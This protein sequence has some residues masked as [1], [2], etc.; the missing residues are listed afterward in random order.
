[1]KQKA[2]PTPDRLGGYLTAVVSV[3]TLAGT[4]DAAVI[5]FS[6][7]GSFIEGTV[8]DGD[9]PV[10][11]ISL[12]DGTELQIDPYFLST[13]LELS[14]TAISGRFTG[15]GTFFGG[16]Y[17]GISLLS[18]GDSIFANNS[19]TYPYIAKL[20]KGEIPQSDFVGDVSGYIGFVTPNNNKGWLS[21]DFNSATGL[22]AYNGGA[23]ATMGEDLTAGATAVSAI[24]EPSSAL[25]TIGLLAG[26]MMI[27]RRKQ[28]A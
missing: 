18:F 19:G 9:Q 8:D 4:A 22:F 20:V 25:A 17:P 12:G 6:N 21:V 24:P 2:K 7:S 15:V 27:R 11:V 10:I 28:A 13:G 26:G 5:T 14:F 23:V 16:F 3:G 1:M